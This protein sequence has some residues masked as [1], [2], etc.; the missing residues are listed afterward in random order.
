MEPI[1]VNFKDCSRL[2]LERNLKL[3]EVENHIVLD[4]WIT[5]SIQY[6]ID[7]IEMQLLTK[8]QK[9]L[10]YRVDDWNEQEL[11]EFFISPVLSLFNFNTQKYGMFS[12]RTMTSTIGDYILSG[13]P[14]LIIASGRREPEIPYFCFHEY[15]KEQE[16][17]GD[18]QGQCLAA[19]IVAQELN[20]NEKPIYGVVVKGVNWFFMVLQGKEYAISKPFKAVDE[21]LFEIVKLLKHLKTIIEEYVKS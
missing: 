12:W 3:I 18:P 2:F 20:N 19:M 11:N 16:N 8:L 5:Q 10:K 4:E 21:E 6:P 1:K 17:K 14:D 9:Q 7:D 13:E 15:K